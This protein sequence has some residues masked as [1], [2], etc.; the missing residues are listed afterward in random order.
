MQ[1]FI[2]SSAA[3][4]GEGGAQR[5]SDA[6]AV[7]ADDGLPFACHLCRNYFK[8]PVVTA[9][10]HYFCERCIMD[11]VRTVDEACPIC[12]KDTS[13]VFNQPAK[14]IAK[15]RQV[16]GRKATWEEY[17]AAFKS[18]GRAGTADDEEG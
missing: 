7:A 6:S 4:G 1:D 15:K 2:S 5:S 16:V 13:S 17:A 12:G 14:L 11:R 10:G 3:G 18:G 9:C 8:D